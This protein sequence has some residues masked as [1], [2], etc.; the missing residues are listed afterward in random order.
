MD[1][2]AKKA[3]DAWARR[4]PVGKIRVRSSPVRPGRRAKK[5]TVD[6]VRDVQNVLNLHN[7][8]S[9]NNRGDASHATQSRRA[10]VVFASFRLLR[11]LGYKLQSARSLKLRHVQALVDEW[12]RDGLAPG[13]IQTN[14]SVLRVYCE[15]INKPGM[16]PPS[17]YLSPSITRSSAALEDKSWSGNGVDV[18]EKLRQVF[19][20]DKRVG[21][22][23]MLC[24]AFGLRRKES[25]ML[26]PHIDDRETVLVIARGAKGGGSG[27]FR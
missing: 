7:G 11:K 22:S 1:K 24:H 17:I 14:L 26:R 2:E 20:Y 15:W 21:V 10:T 5:P 18:S 4:F 23:L 3:A 12:Q 6:W 9:S 19:E 16:I 8:R 27:L 13:T 25:V